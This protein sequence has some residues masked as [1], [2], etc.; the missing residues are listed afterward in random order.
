M[1]FVCQI[2]GYIYDEAKRIWRL[3]SCRIP[4]YARCARPQSLHLL[5]KERKKTTG[6]KKE[7]VQQKRF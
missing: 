2:C 3:T 1:K 4:G 6:K 5:E 7:P